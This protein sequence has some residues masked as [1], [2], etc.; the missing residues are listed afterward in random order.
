MKH[1]NTQTPSA[2]DK[3]HTLTYEDL[4]GLLQ[5]SDDKRH[6]AHLLGALLTEK[7]QQELVNRLNIFALLQQ[8]HSQRDISATLG[9]GIATVSR[10]AKVFHQQQLQDLLPWESLLSQSED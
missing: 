3:H 8:G 4:L 7:E 6:L 10:G 9:V 5:T 1:T 2:N